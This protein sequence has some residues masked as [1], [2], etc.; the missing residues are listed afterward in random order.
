MAGKFEIYEDKAGEYRFRL[1]AG[2]GE[3]ILASEGYKQ[4]ASCENGIASVM[5]NAPED[6]RYERKETKSGK[7]MFNLKATN[8]QVIG[9]SESYESTSGRDNG[10]ES[11]KK[12][13]PD[14]KIDDQTA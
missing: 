11:V 8:G 12:N 7:H 14:A 2:N 9:T 6:A 5:K 13:A 4:K 1:K 3:I 10:I